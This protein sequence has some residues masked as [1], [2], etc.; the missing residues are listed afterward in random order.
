[1]VVSL[2]QRHTSK[3]I[4]S[5]HSEKRV[6]AAASSIRPHTGRGRTLEAVSRVAQS[7]CCACARGDKV[8]AAA[9]LD[10]HLQ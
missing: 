3:C 8:A 7:T 6:V 2:L 1:M 9:G 4:C 5:R 10:T